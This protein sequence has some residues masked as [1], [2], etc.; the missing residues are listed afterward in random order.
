MFLL[1]NILTGLARA[2]EMALQLYIYVL[3]GRA[4]I[5][6]VNADPRNGIVR[7]LV[8]ATEPPMRMI[9]ALLPRSLRYFPLDIAFLVLF[10]LVIFA[11]Y[12]IVQSLLDLG[13]RLRL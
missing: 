1:A 3:I 13:A 10:G 5:S 8:M 6:W 4:V 9:R 2:L 7:F 12:A 11:Q